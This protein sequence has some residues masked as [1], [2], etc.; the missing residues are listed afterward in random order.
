MKYEG[1]FKNN[2][3]DGENSKQYWSNG[4]LL[5]EGGMKLGLKNGY[6][7]WYHENGR[8]RYEGMWLDD[9]PHGE[10]TIYR[11]DGNIAFIDN[12]EKGFDADGSHW[13]KY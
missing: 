13:R 5:Y 12:M 7:K 6:G 4:Y 3:F 10:V 2:L 1:Q 9:G 11:R 8:L